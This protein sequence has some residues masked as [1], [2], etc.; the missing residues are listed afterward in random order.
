R[1]RLR[2]VPRP[3]EGL[4][5]RVAGVD[6]RRS[7]PRLSWLQAPASVAAGD[8]D[9]WIW[10]DTF[11]S[12]LSP[13]PVAATLDLLARAG[14]TGRVIE[15]HACCGLTWHTTGQLEEAE[16]RSTEAVRVL[17]PYLASATPVVAL[18]PSCLAA[19]RDHP[20]AAG[21]LTLAELAERVELPLPD[22]T[23]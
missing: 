19:L 8:P 12:H 23:G 6:S 18:E 9:V 14:L 10:A 7:L 13:V 16:R 20:G 3:L 5:K 2:T 22:L 4:A 1:L 15:E 11:T 21:L 17:T